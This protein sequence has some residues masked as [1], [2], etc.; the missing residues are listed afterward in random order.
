MHPFLS[1]VVALLNLAVVGVT[2]VQ[3]ATPPGDIVQGDVFLASTQTMSGDWQGTKLAAGTGT[4]QLAK[5]EDYTV[6]VTEDEVQPPVIDS[7]RDADPSTEVVW[8]PASSSG[9][10]QDFMDA[11]AQP[12]AVWAETKLYPPPPPPEPKPTA[13]NRNGKPAKP[14]PARRG[15]A[16]AVT[17]PHSNGPIALTDSN[18]APHRFPWGQCTYY[19]S[20]R[21]LIPFRGNAKEWPRTAKAAGFKLGRTPVVGAVVV[22][23]ESWYGHVGYVEKVNDDGS[24]TFSE[25]NYAGL[26]IITRRTMSAGDRRFVTFIY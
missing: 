13:S 25:M 2:P 15:A 7:V 12:I 9:S 1:G 5:N 11:P 6:P 8:D 23:N 24:F 20:T 4:S 18:A 21:R 14:A 19:V 26:G 3:S 16:P 17:T 22:T 10:E